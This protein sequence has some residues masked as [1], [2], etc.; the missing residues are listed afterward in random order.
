MLIFQKKKKFY[1]G[2]LRIEMVDVFGVRIRDIFLVDD[3]PS[4]QHPHTFGEHFPLNTEN[5]LKY[6]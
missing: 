2:R 4:H 5:Q 3:V 6:L 1:L